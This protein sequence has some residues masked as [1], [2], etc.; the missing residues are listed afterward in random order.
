MQTDPEKTNGLEDSFVIHNHKKLR[1]GYTTGTAAAA[2]ARAASGVL[3]GKE[4]PD[5]VEI[6]VPAGKTLHLAIE[7]TDIR[8]D[9]SGKPVAV[10]CSVRKDGGDDVDATDGLLIEATVSRNERKEIVIDGGKGVGRVTRPGLDQPVGNAAINHVPREMIENAVRAS[11]EECSF[12]EGLLVVISVPDGEAIAAKTFNPK[13]GILGG[14]SILGTSGIVWPMSV[15]ALLDTTRTELNARHAGGADYIVVA[16][17]NYGE[18]FAEAMPDLCTDEMITFSNFVGETIDMA[19]DCGYKGMLIVSHIGK[20][21]KVSGGIMN[22]HSH[23]ADCRAELMCTA[24]LRAG[25]DADLCRKLLDTNTTEEALDLLKEKTDDA[26]F[27]SVMTIIAE[28]IDHYLRARV[29][30]QDFLIG[31]VL[32][33]SNHGFLAAT[34]S[35]DPLKERLALQSKRTGM[36]HEQ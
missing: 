8:R 32:F 22:T 31:A 19:I 23:E 35:A 33:S 30:D 34:A 21:I 20:I 5:E 10:T 24:A 13:L 29:R 17:G 12:P 4:I 15:K 11:C 28:R 3:L 27:S 1:C 36:Y 18:R 14:I 7:D 2:A 16:P 9:A 6:D 25:V 26:V